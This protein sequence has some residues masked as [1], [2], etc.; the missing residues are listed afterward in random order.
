MKVMQPENNF[1]ILSSEYK[2][3]RRGYP[4]DVY[5]YI[6]F[7]IN[8]EHSLTLD[9][10]CGTGISTR[11]L[12]ECGFAVTGADKDVAMLA[13]ARE[14]NDGI[15]YVEASAESLPFP[16][17]YFDIVTAF[18]AFHWFNA[19]EPLAEIKRVIK[20]GGLFFAALKGNQETDEAKEF[21]REYQTILRKYAGQNFD[22]TYKHFDKKNLEEL[23]ENVTEKSFPIDEK[24]TIEN[25]LTLLR[26][27]SLWNLVPEEEK[28]N[29]L[30]EMRVFYQSRLVDGFVV[31]KR[32]IFTIAAWKG[33]S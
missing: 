3:A 33:R 26:S 10:G 14:E 28:K 22:S 29:L 27:L 31:R 30:D 9:L 6:E 16:D 1:G 19:L 17:T 20:S 21:N 8:K 18:T 23:F 11:E 15:T 5:G 7:L 25:A 4:S 2:A 13:V 32:E 24:Y 12:K